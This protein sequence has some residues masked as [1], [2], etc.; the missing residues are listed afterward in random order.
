M[1][2]VLQF[3]QKHLATLVQWWFCTNYGKEAPMRKSIYKWH[4]SFAET[5]WVCAKKK[6]SGRRPSDQD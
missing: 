1:T 2:R 6:S 5:G 4:T 3:K